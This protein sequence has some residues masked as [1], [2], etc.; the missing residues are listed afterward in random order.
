MLALTIRGRLQ[1]RR[2]DPSP[3][4][5]LDQA[6]ELA[7]PTGTLQ[8][9]APTAAARSEARW[10]LDMPDDGTDGLLGAYRLACERLD[11]WAIGELGIWMWR[12]GLLDRLPDTAAP[13][14][15]LHVAGDLSGAA[16]EWDALSRP[17]DAAAARADSTDLDELR[18]A[19]EIFQLLGARPAARRAARRLRERGVRGL[20]R[21]PRPQTRADPRGLTEREREVLHLVHEGLSDA[22]IAARL[23][24]STRTVGHHVSALLRKT[25]TQS[26]RQ[27]TVIE[28]TE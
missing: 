7:E 13:P 11:Q 17:Y 20:P 23:F 2:G 1:A 3:W 6:K 5:A 8:R 14:Y 24:L 12:H 26:R 4:P 16:A 15:R 22:Q 21:G 27:L 9:I 19:Y 28:P 10:L 25:G 18:R